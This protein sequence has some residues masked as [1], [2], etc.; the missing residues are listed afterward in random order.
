MF[1]DLLIRRQVSQHLFVD[2]MNLAVSKNADKDSDPADGPSAAD[3]SGSA[4]MLSQERPNA[5]SKNSYCFSSTNKEAIVKYFD[6]LHSLI[7]S[8]G[9]TSDANS[10]SEYW[11]ISDQFL[12]P[13]SEYNYAGNP[14]ELNESCL[15]PQSAI[16]KQNKALIHSTAFCVN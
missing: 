6:L 2:P 14:W 10:M 9:P 4:G 3:G 7:P 13:M 1:D 11:R 15:N 5:M 16:Q 12:L 8:Q